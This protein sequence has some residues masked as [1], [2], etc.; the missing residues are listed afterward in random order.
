MIPHKVIHQLNIP[1]RIRLHG[2]PPTRTISRIIIHNH[3]RMQPLRQNRLHKIHRPYIGRIPMTINQRLRRITLPRRSKPIHHRR[4]VRIRLGIRSNLDSVNSPSK[5]GGSHETRIGDEFVGNTTFR[6]ARVFF[7]PHQS[8]FSKLSGPFGK[9]HILNMVFFVVLAVVRVVTDIAAVGRCGNRPIGGVLTGG[10]LDGAF[11]VRVG[12]F[13]RAGRLKF[14]FFQVSQIGGNVHVVSGIVHRI[15]VVAQVVAFGFVAVF[16]FVFGLLVVGFVG[17]AFV[18][19]VV[20]GVSIG[21]VPFEGVEGWFGGEEHECSGDAGFG[22]AG[23]GEEAEE[24]RDGLGAAGTHYSGFWCLLSRG[25]F[26]VLYAYGGC[27]SLDDYGS[28]G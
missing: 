9:I 1:I 11:F 26:V 2:L 10:V 16:V 20:D 5:G 12:F 8:P 28:T 4:H 24:C 23:A 14:R 13:P 17:N 25:W 7:V 6:I 22:E 3:I 15:I 27:C 21:I 19:V 18:V